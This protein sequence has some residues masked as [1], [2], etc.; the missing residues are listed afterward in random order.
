M[1]DQRQENQNGNDSG[2]E[3]PNSSLVD[4][5]VLE[6]KNE[7]END[8]KYDSNPSQPP[9]MVAG[10]DQSIIVNERKSQ[11]SLM[12]EL[13]VDENKDNRV[14]KTNQRQRNGLS[15]ESLEQR[16]AEI[17]VERAQ[18]DEQL[19]MLNLKQYSHK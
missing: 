16:L 14:G 19:K 6:H 15:K 17:E 5:H 12:L 7:N 11:A 10:V 4:D 18:L 3:R 9:D 2:Q 13:F 1:N 8:N